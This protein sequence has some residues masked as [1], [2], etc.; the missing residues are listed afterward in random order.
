M[1][2]KRPNATKD[3]GEHSLMKIEPVRTEEGYEAAIAR[4]EEIFGI[5][6]DAP[7]AAELEILLALTEDYEKRHHH[8]EPPDPGTA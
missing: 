2:R 5:P 1:C 7:E 8:V 4:I 3:L 6:L